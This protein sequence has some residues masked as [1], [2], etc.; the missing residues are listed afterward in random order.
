MYYYSPHGSD[1][2]VSWKQSVRKALSTNV[3]QAHD[4]DK[5]NMKIH[6]RHAESW[7]SLAEERCNKVAIRTY[8]Y[9]GEAVLDLDLY[10]TPEE[11]TRTKRI[12]KEL[13]IMAGRCALRKNDVVETSIN[14]ATSA[15]QY[16]PFGAIRL[17]EMNILN[18][19]LAERIADS[20]KSALQAYHKDHRYLIYICHHSPQQ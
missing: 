14:Q 10:A 3:D 7:S 17:L 9:N 4:S 12:M 15:Q 20:N 6:H 5:I 16:I 2:T 11:A 18:A 1:I 13:A 8:G 19:G